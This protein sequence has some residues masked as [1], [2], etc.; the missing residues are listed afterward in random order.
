MRTEEKKN[1]Q[2]EE[3]LSTS[4]VKQ[5][6]RAV[7]LVM[8]ETI[9][10]LL[11]AITAYGTH[12]LASYDYEELSPTIYRETTTAGAK[13]D[14]PKE[15]Q[16]SIVEETNE[17]GVVIGSSEVE[18]PA[19]AGMSGYRNILL[20]GLDERSQNLADNG[21]QTDVMMIMSINNET[22]DIKLVSILRD[23]VMRMEE[24]CNVPYEKA[25]HQFAWSGLSDTVSMVNRNLGLDIGEYVIVN[26]AGVAKVVDILGG[27]EMTIPNEEILSYFNG[28]L[29]DVNAK[30]GINAPQLP[31]PGTYVMRGTQVV[32]FCRIRY[33]GYNDMG[34]TQHQREA[35]EK[36]L[37]K[38]KACMAAGDIN[39]VLS[40]AETGLS[41]VRTNLTLPEVLYMATE[42][43]DYT[44]TG[45]AQ[46][47]QEY[48][49]AKMLGNYPG[50]YGVYDP[51][52]ANDFAKEVKDLHQFLFD[53]PYYE[54]SD[55]IK[56]VS[57]QMYLDRIGQ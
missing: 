16:T 44:I 40:A 20:L 53:D 2:P 17:E 57:Y 37:E 3:D 14:R 7:I 4:R 39:L 15:K 41:S 33:G 47:P 56:N 8:V 18:I 28:Y 50:K 30:T 48:S 55:F 42:V 12:V 43:T 51:L 19:S 29:T 34:R 23:T 52:V 45:S 46:F 9:L 25:N 13:D 35:I 22:G 38:A 54:P 1:I 32:A 5:R 21:T 6:R 36:I 49:T 10:M 31:A 24:N 26:W 11:L 27:I